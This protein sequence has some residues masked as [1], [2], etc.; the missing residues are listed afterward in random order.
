MVSTIHELFV[1]LFTRSPA[2]LFAL[3]PELEQDDAVAVLSE[4]STQSPPI[5]YRAD[6][7]LQVGY[8]P[9]ALI[10]VEVQ[11]RFDKHKRWRWPL[12]LAAASA[13]HEL[14]STLVVVALKDSVARWAAG[15]FAL[16][17]GA[18]LRPVVVSPASVIDAVGPELLRSSPHLAVAVMAFYDLAQRKPPDSFG[19]LALDAIANDDDDLAEDDRNFYTD[20]VLAALSDKLRAEM[21]N[22]MNLQNWKPRT[23]FVRDMIAQR[24][25]ARSEGIAQGAQ[26]GRLAARRD[27][28]RTVLTARTLSL[29]PADEA[30]I[31]ACEDGQLLSA[32]IRQAA[33]AD[34]VGEALREAE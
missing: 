18:E 15:P 19:L 30:L 32:W 31:E 1:Q 12:Y 34:S 17:N 10:V 24:A 26:F 13:R 4:D 8:P 22:T 29:S 2:A 14:P 3:A 20:I 25:A 7:V 33:T 28:L 21:E 11:R 23:K 5:E 6:A 27:A 9:R 16:S